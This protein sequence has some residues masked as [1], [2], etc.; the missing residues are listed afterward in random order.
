MFRTLAV[1]AAIVLFGCA[2]GDRA[3]APPPII[4]AD[5]AT[6]NYAELVG[7]LRQVAWR[8]T[9]SFYRDD[10]ATLDD[11]AESLEK[12][13]TVLK[14]TKN[15]PPRIQGVLVSRCDEL[16]AES[17]KVKSAAAA[18]SADQVGNHLQRV[19]ILI[20]ELRPDL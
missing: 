19:H 8:A 3:S 5:G 1:V 9:E 12:A 11:A 10:W 13:A 6:V 7:S 2:T 18:R 4:P 14:Q 16:F 20:R 15:V 17:A